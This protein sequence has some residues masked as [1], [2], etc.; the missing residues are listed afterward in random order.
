MWCTETE[1]LQQLGDFN[2]CDVLDFGCISARILL[3]P[4]IST[5]ITYVCHLCV[6]VSTLCALLACV[7]TRYMQQLELCISASIITS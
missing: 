3:P 7:K 1:A 2:Q 5:T 4:T 6:C